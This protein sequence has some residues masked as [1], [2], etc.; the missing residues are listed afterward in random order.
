MRRVRS[1][2]HRTRRSPTWHRQGELDGATPAWRGA[3]G[4]LW[5]AS[6]E[7]IRANYA[8]WTRKSPRPNVRSPGVTC[9]RVDDA[10]RR[11]RRGAVL[12]L[13]RP[14]GRR[15]AARPRRLAAAAQRLERPAWCSPGC[16]AARS[17][18]SRPR[19]SST[20]AGP[21]RRAAVLP[22]PAVGARLAN[23]EERTLRSSIG[24]GLLSVGGVRVPE[25][26]R[27]RRRRRDLHRHALPLCLP[28]GAR[29]ADRLR[30]PAQQARRRSSRRLIESEP[31]R[32]AVARGANS[33]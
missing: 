5:A 2:P 24:V 9:R 29:R 10:H 22:G 8:P 26:R 13:A 20:T 28:V 6:L 33:G 31:G 3:I 15:G 21:V 19:R 18:C 14:G 16:S 23:A 32:L 7:V 12:A 4:T 17:W 27:G 25:P 1:I 30:D 11:T